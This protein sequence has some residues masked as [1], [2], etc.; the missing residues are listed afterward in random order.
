[1]TRYLQKSAEEELR[2]TIADCFELAAAAAEEKIWQR[3]TSAIAIG[4]HFQQS[5]S[6]AGRVPRRAHGRT[7]HYHCNAGIDTTGVHWTQATAITMTCDSDATFPCKTQARC[8]VQE[9]PKH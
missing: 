6:T 2:S 7:S 9:W 4:V 8:G 5:S 1:M 3:V